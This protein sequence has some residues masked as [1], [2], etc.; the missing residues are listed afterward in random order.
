MGVGNMKKF[1]TFGATAALSL[2]GACKLHASKFA[3][4]EKT[5]LGL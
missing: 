1:A 2:L 5:A 3:D 4:A